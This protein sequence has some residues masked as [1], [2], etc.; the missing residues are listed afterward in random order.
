[1]REPDIFSV[2]PFSPK[3][4]TYPSIFH[5]LLGGRGLFERSEHHWDR[6]FGQQRSTGLEKPA[7]GKWKTEA[8]KQNLDLFTGD[9]YYSFWDLVTIESQQLW[10]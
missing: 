10:L 9:F 4:I 2:T 8:K 6:R 1:M 7:K 5:K 3:I